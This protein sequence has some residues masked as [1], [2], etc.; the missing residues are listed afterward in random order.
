[1]RIIFLS[2]E[3][4]GVV[5]G[6]SGVPPAIGNFIEIEVEHD[7]PILTSPNHFKIVDGELVDDGVKVVLRAQREIK[8]RELNE[9][10]EEEIIKG[11]T[12]T[13]QGV[14]Y[15]FPLD[16]KAQSR[17]QGAKALFDDGIIEQMNWTA[18]IVETKEWVRIPITKSIMNQFTLIIASHIDSKISRYREVLLPLV[19]SANTVEEIESIHWNMDLNSQQIQ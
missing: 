11:F 19:S 8:D 10:C 3:D 6:W 14:Q 17:F 1:L 5:N 7:H 13:H 16:M 15:L 2:L 18:Q 9:N 4:S 12:Y